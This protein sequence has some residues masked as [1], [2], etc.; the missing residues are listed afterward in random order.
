LNSEFNIGSRPPGQAKK[1]AHAF[2]LKVQPRTA[3]Q[4][5]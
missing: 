4:D 3:D 2:F 5:R 1:R